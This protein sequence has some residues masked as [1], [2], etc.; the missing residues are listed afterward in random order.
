[1][2]L[3]K[4]SFLLCVLFTANLNSYGGNNPVPQPIYNAVEGGGIIVMDDVILAITLHNPSDQ[5]AQVKIFNEEQELVF[6]N[7]TCSSSNCT[8]N[9]SMLERGIYTVVVS[10]NQQDS[11]NAQIQR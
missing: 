5:I 9:L 10:T 6:E 11:F 3:L 2:S 7:T 4:F 8:F 1:M